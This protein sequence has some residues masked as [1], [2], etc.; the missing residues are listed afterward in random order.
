[1]RDKGAHPS[2]LPYLTQVRIE[3][4][5]LKTIQ[6]YRDFQAEVAREE[7]EEAGPRGPAV[8]GKRNSD[9]LEFEGM[10]PEPK[11]SVDMLLC[12]RL[13]GRDKLDDTQKQHLKQLLEVTLQ[14]VCRGCFGLNTPVR[15]APLRCIFHIGGGEHPPNSAVLG[16]TLEQ[17]W[18]RRGRGAKGPKHDL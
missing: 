2:T 13:H 3:D 4:G 10:V 6:W 7:A 12:T 11:H 17:C 1:M 8:I 18:C 15:P 5:V 14:V 16:K 9:S